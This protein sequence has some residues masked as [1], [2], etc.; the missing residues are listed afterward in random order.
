MIAVTF[1]LPTESAVFVHLLRDARHEMSIEV[2]H[3]GVGRRSCQDK[4]DMFLD[5]QR[6]AILISAGFA[7]ALSDQ[8]KIG[9]ILLAENFSTPRTLQT[10]REL[11]ADSFT[12]IGKLFTADAIVDS[13][14]KRNEIARTTSAIA[15]DMETEWIAA[16]CAARDIPLLSLRAISDTPGKPLP[17]PPHVL[18]DLHRQKTEFGRLALY[19]LKHPPAVLRLI[20]FARRIR[21]ARNS[22]AAALVIVCEELSSSDRRTNE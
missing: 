2:F 18:F 16:A 11:L 8:L 5:A 20:A 10:A 9:D 6:P 12:R 14:E 3:T 22:L 1:A 7:G 13:I 19:L 15:V 4:I 17:A 21:S